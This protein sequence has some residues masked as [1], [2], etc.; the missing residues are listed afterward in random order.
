MKNLSESQRQQIYKY[1]AKIGEGSFGVV[2]LAKK[3]GSEQLYAIKIMNKKFIE[4]ENKMKCLL[5]EIS[6]LS[7]I[8][9]KN[10][11]KL[12]SYFVTENN[13]YLVM[14]YVNGGTLEECLQKYKLKFGKPFS[15]EIVQ[16]LM[17]QILE[18]LYYLH[19]N[20][21]VHRDLK[22]ENIMVH[23]DNEIDKQN[24]NMLKAKVKIIDFGISNHLNKKKLLQSVAGTLKNMDPAIIENYRRIISGSPDQKL[25][26][27]DEKCDIW[28]IGT[29]CY[30]LA[31]G[32]IVF[33]FQDIEELWNKIQIGKYKLPKTL[34]IEII[35]FINSM[36]VL[37]AKKRSSAQELLNHKFITEKIEDF[38]YIETKITKEKKKDFKKSIWEIFEEGDKLI[39][40]KEG[41]NSFPSSNPIPELNDNDFTPINHYQSS[42][43][44]HRNEIEKERAKLG[45]RGQS[46]YGQSM[47]PDSYQ[48]NNNNNNNRNRQYS[49]PI[50][51][52][53]NFYFYP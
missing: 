28:S 47:L 27:Y 6:F 12:D 24:L 40:I 5:N 4:K 33:Q 38:K 49:S 15:E 25:N 14:E 46:F 1:K 26:L 3:N 23:F 30:E 31:I 43:S 48:N 37:D 35:S 36:L 32:K 22:L 9:H 45:L 10:I 41:D 21:I 18:A 44:I 51:Q 13:Y 42:D 53:N 11:A 50:N 20:K 52:I 39:K 19:L 34:S 17:R 7:M 8:N 16:H 29:I 2:W